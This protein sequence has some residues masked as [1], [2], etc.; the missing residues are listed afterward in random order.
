MCAILSK[1][2]WDIIYSY[3]NEKKENFDKLINEYHAHLIFTSFDPSARLQL[4]Q[5]K[6]DS[7]ID[8]DIDFFETDVEN[9][10]MQSVVFSLKNKESIQFYLNKYIKNN[11]YTHI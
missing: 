6:T 7:E 4:I 1:E 8:K 5:I 3:D 10:I 2:L 11:C 9:R